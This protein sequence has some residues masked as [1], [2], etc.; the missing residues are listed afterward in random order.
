MAT[1]IAV[2]ISYSAAGVDFS[3]LRGFANVLARP[4]LTMMARMPAAT[5]SQRTRVAR[6][7]R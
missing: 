7:E 3:S 4:M 6:T 1:E 5:T 2:A